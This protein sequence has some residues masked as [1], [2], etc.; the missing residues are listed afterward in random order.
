MFLQEVRRRIKDK[1]CVCFSFSWCQW[2]VIVWPHAQCSV[3]DN[4]F[5]HYHKKNVT[6]K[7][8]EIKWQT[9]IFKFLSF[10]IGIKKL[11]NTN[12]LWIS[13]A[14]G[15]QLWQYK[16]RIVIELYTWAWLAEENTLN[17]AAEVAIM[18]DSCGVRN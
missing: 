1:F 15:L 6:G 3:S 10:W 4:Q 7:N 13:A 5:R 9:S 11:C 18:A 8:I 14:D 17:R 12:G 16:Y 2:C